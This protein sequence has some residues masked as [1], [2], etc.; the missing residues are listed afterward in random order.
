M[1]VQPQQILRTYKLSKLVGLASISYLLAIAVSIT[2][3]NPASAEPPQ[4]APAE[5]KNTLTQI[6]AAANRQQIEQLIQFYSPSFTNSDGLSRQ[7]LQDG[8]VN[9]WEKYPGLQYKTELSSW[10]RDRKGFV[11]ETVTT[12]SGVQQTGGRTVKLESKMRSRQTIQAQKIVSQEI[13]AERSQVTSGDKPPTVQ[14]S[15][16]PEKLKVGQEYSFDAIV[17]EPLGEDLLLGAA[18][19]QPVKTE[20]YFQPGKYELKDLSAGGIFKTG[21]LNK[22]GDYWLSAVFVRSGGMTTV[23]QRLKVVNRL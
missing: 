8:L 15:A 4:T 9:F 6:D 17:K 5:V 23:V 11:V 3:L 13:L 16:L 2:S 22:A 1:I 14:L 20:N 10:K 12:I 19:E 7:K 18:S 21:K